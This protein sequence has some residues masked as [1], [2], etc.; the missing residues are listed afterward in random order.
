MFFTGSWENS[1]K[2][3]RKAAK[4]DPV[5]VEIFCHDTAEL[6]ALLSKFP[7]GDYATPDEIIRSP[8][9][10]MAT[11]RFAEHLVRLRKTHYGPV[12]PGEKMEVTADN[13]RF[14]ADP[15]PDG[16]E[17]YLLNEFATY[18]LLA[19]TLTPVCCRFRRWVAN[20]LMR[21][22]AE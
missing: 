16:S 4:A 3:L 7:E 20:N 12:I 13:L 19:Q 10:K 1:R 8:T 21:E 11:Y 22:A 2:W 15:N 6:V 5:A 18:V 9:I 17:G 14:L